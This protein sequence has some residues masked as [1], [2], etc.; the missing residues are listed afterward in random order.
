LKAES[1]ISFEEVVEQV[2]TI[3]HWLKTSKQ[4]LDDNP[5]LIEFKMSRL[6]NGLELIIESQMINGDG[7]ASTM[8]GLLKT[9]NFTVFTPDAGDTQID[10][11]RKG[12]LA[13]EN[14]EEFMC[15]MIIMNQNDVAAI[16]LL[17]DAD[18]DYLV[19][20]PID[21]GLHSLWGKPLLSSKAMTAG[22]FIV[23]DTTQAV[24]THTR[25]DALV[26][27]SNSDSDNFVK[28]LITILA[29]VR[30]GFAVHLPAG[31]ISGALIL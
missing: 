19:G 1:D 31:V 6:R 21:G 29:E 18:G 14:T 22:Q 11:I 4:V 28:N 15:D 9:G 17:K 25:A 8:N 20:K 13:L 26:E 23:L 27:F 30:I 5:A 10:S 24:T 2:P 3:A 16:E 7:T 12:I